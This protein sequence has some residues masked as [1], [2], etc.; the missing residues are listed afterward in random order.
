MTVVEATA[1]EADGDYRVPAL[2]R[3]LRVLELFDAKRRLLTLQEIAEGLG[4][5]TSSVY[6][7]V[8][9]LTELGYLE[10][11]SRTGY[12]LGI[13]VVSQGFAYLASR[14]L[15]DIAQPHLERLRDV[16][17]LSCHLGIRDRT[18]V[19]YL[20]R[21]MA[22]QRLTVNVPVGTRLPCTRTALGRVLLSGL[23]AEALSALYQH[24]R[25]DDQPPPAPRTLPELLRLVEQ[26][27]RQGWVLHRSDYSTAIAT[28][29]RDHR[30]Q[31]VAA[32][33]VSGP[34]AVMDAAAT[35]EWGGALLAETAARIATELGHRPHADARRSD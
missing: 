11:Q 32:L 4:G 33:N 22:S 13:K 23:Y 27:R 1:V 14:D 28:G 17:S 19:V 2:L 21:A 26:D 16:T 6:R 15:V 3:G 10:R 29:I 31:L 7:I 5:S 12:G 20:Y 30:D 34:D 24:E 9:T 35:R 8:M 25:L 18:E